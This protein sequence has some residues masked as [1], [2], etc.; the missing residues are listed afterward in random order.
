MEHIARDLLPHC[1]Y[2]SRTARERDIAHLCGLGTRS[3][4]EFLAEIARAHDIADDIA[5]RLD[6]YR[7]LSPEMVAVARADRFAPAPTREVGQ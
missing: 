5:R 1:D 3:V 7:R 4:A 2:G 6:L